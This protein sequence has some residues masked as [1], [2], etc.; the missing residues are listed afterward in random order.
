MFFFKIAFQHWLYTNTTSDV[1][2]WQ[3]NDRLKATAWNRHISH[4][5]HG[6]I[7][8]LEKEKPY[9]LVVWAPP[10]TDERN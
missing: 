8:D 2:K 5:P 3:L 7:K 10:E 4:C 9:R 1:P 6:E